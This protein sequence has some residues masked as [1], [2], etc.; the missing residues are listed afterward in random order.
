MKPHLNEVY[1][2]E[3]FNGTKQMFQLHVRMSFFLFLKD[4]VVSTKLQD[5]HLTV[6]IFKRLKASKHTVPLS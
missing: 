1:C 6:S 5:A 3:L 4:V 2:G